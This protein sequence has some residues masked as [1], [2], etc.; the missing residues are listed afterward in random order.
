MTSPVRLVQSSSKA[1]PPISA[2]FTQT[3]RTAVGGVQ[4]RWS[5][6][7]RKGTS[8]FPLLPILL[9]VLG[10]LGLGLLG[11]GFYF[12]AVQGFLVFLAGM[13]GFAGHMRVVLSEGFLAV[14]LVR[15]FGDRGLRVQFGYPQLRL[16]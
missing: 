2:R 9:S 1:L 16:D 13:L 3:P 7:H 12:F 11:V 8:N 10:C 6:Y 14:Q 4:S 15:R 5:G